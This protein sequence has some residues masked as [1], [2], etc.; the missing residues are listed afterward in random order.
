MFLTLMTSKNLIGRPDTEG[1]FV[2]KPK[3]LLS[4]V[5]II[6][7]CLQSMAAFGTTSLQ[8]K[9]LVTNQIEQFIDRYAIDMAE[10]GVRSNYQIGN[11]PPL[12]N[13]SV[14]C[15]NGLEMRFTRSPLLYSELTIELRCSGTASVREQWKIYVPI[16]IKLYGKRVALSEA[17]P[18]NS[19]IFSSDLE[20]R[21][22]QINGAD[23]YSFEH[24]AQAS[25]FVTKRPLARGIFLTEKML[26]PPTLVNR[27]D[28][29]TILAQSPIISVKMQGTAMSQGKKNQQIHVKNNQSKRVI[30]ALVLDTGLVKVAL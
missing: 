15:L 27:G 10:Q 16:S 22:T 9:Q 21:E 2:R 19:P 1:L 6:I 23:K 24:F 11:L 25:G 12:H 13:K 3:L 20:M 8:K 5:A 30:K 18:R 28:Q 7:A 26:T 29:V 14:D 17:K 4:V